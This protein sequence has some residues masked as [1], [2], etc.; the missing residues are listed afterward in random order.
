ML[1]IDVTQEKKDQLIKTFKSTPDRRLRDRCQ[2]VL[3]RAEKRTQTVIA[4]D[5]HVTRRTLYNWLQLYVE[6]GLEGLRIEW[7]AGKPPRIPVRM[8]PVIQKWVK[9]GPAECGLNRANWT[10]AEL[11]DYL[12]KASGIWVSETTMRDFCHRHEMRPYRPTYRFLR[13]DPDKKQPAKADI[14]TLKKTP[15]TDTSSC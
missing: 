14:A 4:R 13:A 11:A 6:N 10:Y 7:G 12:Y 1:Q 15:Q 2:A 3:M 9:Q 8:V 5:L